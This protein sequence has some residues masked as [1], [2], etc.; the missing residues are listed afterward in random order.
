MNATEFYKKWDS[1]IEKSST[2]KMN[3]F[4]DDMDDLLDDAPVDS[5]FN[6]FDEFDEFDA[7]EFDTDVAGNDTDLIKEAQASHAPETNPAN[8][9]HVFYKNKVASDSHDNNKTIEPLYESLLDFCSKYDYDGE[10]FSNFLKSYTGI[11]AEE[12][13]AIVQSLYYLFGVQ[14]NVSTYD[15]CILNYSFEEIKRV[16]SAYR[17][18]TIGELVFIYS[19]KDKDYFDSN[20]LKYLSLEARDTSMILN[21]L[22]K[23]EFSREEAILYT[24]NADVFNAYL[25]LKVEGSFDPEVFNKVATNGGDTNLY[26]KSVLEGNPLAILG[27]HPDFGKIMQLSQTT[28][29][30]PEVIRRYQK[31][32]WLYDILL[33]STKGVVNDT[34]IQRVSQKPETIAAQMMS[35]Y[36]S[37]LIDYDVLNAANGDFNVAKVSFDLKRMNNSE[38]FLQEIEHNF[39]IF[40][41]F[42]EMLV[43]NLLEGKIDYKIYNAFLFD[44]ASRNDWAFVAEVTEALVANKSYNQFYFEKLLFVAGKR[45]NVPRNIGALMLLQTNTGFTY[46]SVDLLRVGLNNVAQIIENPDMV[47]K[48]LPEQKGLIL[49]KKDFTEFYKEKQKLSW[50]CAPYDSLQYA[51][52]HKIDDD[53]IHSGLTQMKT[54]SHA[55]SAADSFKQLYDL[56]LEKYCLFDPLIIVMITK[57]PE[58]CGIITSQDFISLL[59]IFNAALVCKDRDAVKVW[60]LVKYLSC[61]FG[62]RLTM[63]PIDFNNLGNINYVNVK[64]NYLFNNRDISDVFTSLDVL[65]RELN[66]SNNIRVYTQNNTICLEGN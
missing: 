28:E 26:T 60:F 6:E 48:L 65:V 32:P 29:L 12:T 10:S 25:S 31:S 64:N 7:D 52:E 37:G 47:V 51:I 61:K 58:M 21:L 24:D 15:P 34:F 41:Y 63:Q 13:E 54:L 8:N 50:F 59:K 46:V 20:V 49:C 66:K 27:D 1:N 56:Q 45:V 44:C 16:I 9:I 35:S 22:S 43:S 55:T 5:D 62:K 39:G 33:A 42:A 11:V 40:S 18:T 30:A 19:H 38:S 53:M 3:M 2:Q 23:G 36:G 4:A 57:F 17:N 14:G